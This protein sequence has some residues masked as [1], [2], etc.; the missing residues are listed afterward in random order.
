MTAPTTKPSPKIFFAFRLRFGE[1][2][3]T[4]RT[5]RDRREEFPAGFQ[6]N[7]PM[8]VLNLIA[9]HRRLAPN[10]RDA[11]AFVRGMCE[12]RATID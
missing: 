6:A 2:R 7:K 5:L 4:V 8:S 3:S 10:R 1:D 11:V 12:G 9:K